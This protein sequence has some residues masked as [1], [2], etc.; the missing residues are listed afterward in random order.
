M[1]VEEMS[2]S[3]LHT[4]HLQIE[5][6]DRGGG[7]GDGGGVS[8]GGGDGS[9][10]SAD[11][12]Y[13]INSQVSPTRSESSGGSSNDT[14]HSSRDFECMIC[15]YPFYDTKKGET[16]HEDEEVCLC[17]V[18]ASSFHQKCI[19]MWRLSQYQ[20]ING[21]DLASTRIET[22]LDGV[23]QMSGCPK[24]HFG[25]RLAS[26]K[27]ISKSCTWLPDEL[28]R[29]MKRVNDGDIQIDDDNDG[30]NDGDSD[31]DSDGNSDGDSELVIGRLGES[32]TVPRDWSHLMCACISITIVVG[33]LLDQNN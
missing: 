1:S 13:D 28:S 23:N 30:N 14:L 21:S 16:L 26:E 18:C 22:F 19:Q 17:P 8:D 20:K 6:S 24:C 32:I 15:F 29:N 7:G 9:G 27:N 33:F 31:G 25:G 4:D 10:S 11:E 12:F 2:E 3:L 5:I